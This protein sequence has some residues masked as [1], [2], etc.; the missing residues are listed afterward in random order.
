MTPLSTRVLPILRYDRKLHLQ[1]TGCENVFALALA[2]VLVP[3][4]TAGGA[5]EWWE[6]HESCPFSF[7]LALV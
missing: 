2:L 7:S 4:L 5:S 1:L 6:V 3:W